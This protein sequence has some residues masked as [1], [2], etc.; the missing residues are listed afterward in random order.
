M[1][2]W[3]VDNVGLGE[4]RYLCT[5]CLGQPNG[6]VVCTRIAAC[7]DACSLGFKKQYFGYEQESETLDRGDKVADTASVAVGCADCNRNCQMATS[8]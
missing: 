6:C 4:K 1:E 8:L 3:G 2:L 7:G 5:A